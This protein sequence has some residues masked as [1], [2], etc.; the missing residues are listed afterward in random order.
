MLSRSG[1][2]LHIDFFRGLGLLWIFVDHTPGDWFSRVTFSHFGVCDAF[3]LFVLLA[4]LSAGYA[5]GLTVQRRGVAVAAGRVLHRSA[6]IY[7]AN[8]LVF[9]VLAIEVHLLNP[10]PVGQ[11]VI[12]M[13]DLRSIVSFTLPDTGA[14]LTFNYPAGLVDILPLY[15][16]L[17]LGLTLVLPLLRFP[18]R[19][20]ALS[21]A[22]YVATVLFDLQLPGMPAGGSV[23][24]P[25][26]YFNPL[27]W[28]VLMILGTVL[29]VEPSILPMPDPALDML[30]VTFVLTGAAVQVSAYLHR[31]FAISMPGGWLQPVADWM[32]AALTVDKAKMNLHPLR[33]A[34]ILGWA[35]LAYRLRPRYEGWLTQPWA[36]PLVLCGQHSLPVFCVGVALAPIGGLWL[37]LR[38]GLPDQIAYNL[39]G[40][41]VL[42]ATAALA[43]ALR[44]R[45]RRPVVS[46]TLVT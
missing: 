37:A 4:G 42:A 44:T 36:R 1:R 28:Q 14:L 7:A 35:W 9:A 33:L 26:F 41:G 22:L 31:H 21:V 32:Q 15:V 45:Q 43:A 6:T 19:L 5:Y 11:S 16:L 34:N 3:E 30:A 40:I 25:Y 23:P 10:L 12:D 24:A 8:L 18:R 38:G 29:V 46:S 13:M 2:N 17:F 20:L 27:A 39:A